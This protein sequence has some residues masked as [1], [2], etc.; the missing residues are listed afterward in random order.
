MEVLWQQ[1][2]IGLIVAAAVAF[3]VIRYVRRR[4]RKASGCDNCALLKRAQR[5]R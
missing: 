2:A 4:N 1:L 5:R 3:L